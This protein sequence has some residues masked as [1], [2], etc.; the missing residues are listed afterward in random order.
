HQLLTHSRLCDGRATLINLCDTPEP[1]INLTS[2]KIWLPTEQK[3]VAIILKNARDIGSHT[4]CP[5]FTQS[6]PLNMASQKNS[7]K[8]FTPANL[9]LLTRQNLASDKTKAAAV[10]LT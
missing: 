4:K 9:T 8:V 6:R 1:S 3:S 5:A 10:T 7:H 2:A